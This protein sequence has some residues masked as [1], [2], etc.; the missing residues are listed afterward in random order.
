MPRAL[1]ATPSL[2]TYSARPPFGSIVEGAAIQ[3]DEPVKSCGNVATPY[4]F[5]VALQTFTGETTATHVQL[6]QASSNHV[7]QRWASSVY[8]YSQSFSTVKHKQKITVTC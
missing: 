5:Y 3:P 7:I 2:L 6:S 8:R 4:F 1:Q